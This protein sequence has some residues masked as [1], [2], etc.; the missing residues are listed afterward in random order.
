MIVA[1]I[2][3]KDKRTSQKVQNSCIRYSFNLQKYDV[4]SRSKWQILG[5]RFIT[6]YFIF[7]MKNSLFFSET[8]IR[9][10]TF[11]TYL[12]ETVTRTHKTYIKEIFSIHTFQ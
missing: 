9:D 7:K 11:I 5:K 3:V 6:S 4:F 12:L 10:V 2:N 8:L 1:G